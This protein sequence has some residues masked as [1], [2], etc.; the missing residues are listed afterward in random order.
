MVDKSHLMTYCVAK[1]R[2]GSG[3]SVATEEEQ[4]EKE[5]GLKADSVSLWGDFVFSIA[6]V[7]P[8]S[9]VAYTLALLLTFAGHVA[10][11]A[12]LV[13]GL[14]MSACAVGYASLNR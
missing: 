13:V 8:S 10:P 2:R 7:A 6:N 9:S 12:V 4:I 3:G 1:L 14:G 11:L 5:L